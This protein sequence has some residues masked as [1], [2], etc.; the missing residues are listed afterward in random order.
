VI[1][2]ALI[3]SW[4]PGLLAPRSP[5][6]PS[7]ELCLLV[8]CGRLG[9]PLEAALKDGGLQS[10]RAERGD[11]ALDAL[12]HRS[13]ALVVLGSGVNGED[14]IRLLASLHGEAT[15]AAILYLANSADRELASRALEEG[16]DD[17]VPPPHSVQA[18]L[19]RAH[20]V[21]FRRGAAGARG[22]GSPFGP[23]GAGVR[24]GRLAVDLKGRRLLDGGHEVVLSGREFE[25]LHRLLEAEG[26]V[27]RRTELVEDIWGGGQE[28]EG[29]LDAT[30][31]RLRRKL[32]A[33]PA[34]PRILV[35]VRGVGY[36][37]EGLAF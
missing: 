37:V 10:L 13:P 29:V 3:W 12:R 31:H 2:T 19:L 18:I 8:G 7:R 28:S 15:N 21:A 30:V 26:G 35:T 17:V 16:A 1:T 20:V 23:N 27:V 36:R 24:L 25:L 4:A 11:D 22:P 32:E 6:D 9:E 14:P 5:S 34:S 33:D